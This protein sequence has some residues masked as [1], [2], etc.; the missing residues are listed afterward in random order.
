MQSSVCLGSGKL[1]DRHALPA[2]DSN[3]GF[4]QDLLSGRRFLIDTGASV[5][6]FPQ[7]APTPSAPLSQTKLLTASSFPL[8]CFWAHSIPLPFGSR[9]FF[10]SFQFAPVF[11]PI[12]GSNFLCHHTLLVNVARDR[13][14]D[15]DSQDVLPPVSSPTASIYSRLP[16]KC[17]NSS[18]SSQTS[19]LSIVFSLYT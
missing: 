6:V 13:V 15:A 11:V 18:R 5:S 7:T 1:V 8:P 16:E 19:S 17:G 3:L 9:H 2:R 14:L 4:L 12:L 10:W